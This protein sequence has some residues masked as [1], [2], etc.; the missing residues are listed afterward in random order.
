M[1]RRGKGLNDEVDWGLIEII[2]MY[3]YLIGVNWQ[4]DKWSARWNLNL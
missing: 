4:G 2:F 3:N 1:F